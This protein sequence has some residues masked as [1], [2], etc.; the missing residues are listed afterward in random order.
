MGKCS[1]GESYFEGMCLRSIDNLTKGIRKVRS[2]GLDWF[3]FELMRVLEGSEGKVNKTENNF[4]YTT[5]RSS[6]VTKVKYPSE[7]SS[8]DLLRDTYELNRLEQLASL[9][10]LFELLD[11]ASLGLDSRRSLKMNRKLEECASKPKSRMSYAFKY[12][13]S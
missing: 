2:E 10:K 3:K 13:D 9:K 1:E 8:S 4:L 5:P 12:W 11:I 6:A 7:Y